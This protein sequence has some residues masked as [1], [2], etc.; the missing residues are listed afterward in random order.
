MYVCIYIAGRFSFKNNTGV[1]SNE[2]KV[3]WK[4]LIENNHNISF[5]KSVAFFSYF[6]L[7]QRFY[8]NVHFN[9]YRA[10][11]HWIAC[12]YGTQAFGPYTSYAHYILIP[13]SHIFP[14]D[15]EIFWSSSKTCLT[16][17]APE[18]DDWHFKNYNLFCLSVLQCMSNL[19][20]HLNLYILFNC[21]RNII[22][23]SKVN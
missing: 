2:R 22:L 5:L 16:L 9:I 19:E 23:W 21:F 15:K 12:I 14:L 18:A 3:W 17:K 20:F 4:C 10:V 8:R 13:A 6:L 1:K 11:P 7:P